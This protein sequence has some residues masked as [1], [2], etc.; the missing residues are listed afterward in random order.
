MSE[1]VRTHL[2]DLYSEPNARLEEY[3]DRDLSHWR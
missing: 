2:R 3:L 1:E